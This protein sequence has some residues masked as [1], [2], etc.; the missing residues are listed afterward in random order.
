M[1]LIISLMVG[2]ALATVW[3]AG[4]ATD[5]YPLPAGWALRLKAVGE[6]RYEQAYIAWKQGRLPDFVMDTVVQ[7]YQAMNEAYD[8]YLTSHTVAWRERA[9]AAVQEHVRLMGQR[10]IGAGIAPV[11]QYP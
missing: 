4:A 6:S 8:R 11:G 10:L 7:D 2:L 1:T 5:T 9:T 3:P